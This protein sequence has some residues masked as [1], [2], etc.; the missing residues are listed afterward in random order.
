MDDGCSH[1]K[2]KQT[3][4]DQMNILFNKLTY[5]LKYV[6]S[7]SNKNGTKIKWFLSLFNNKL[8]CS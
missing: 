6:K 7:N 8:T 4:S 1:L 3:E 5:V 2:W